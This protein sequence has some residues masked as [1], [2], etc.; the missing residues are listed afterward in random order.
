M[1]IELFT[2]CQF[3]IIIPTVGMVSSNCDPG[4]VYYPFYIFLQFSPKYQIIDI[5]RLTNL[6][7]SDETLENNDP[8]TPGEF[9][10]VLVS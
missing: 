9:L 4:G 6:D 8:A 1:T 7:L 2:P 5:V 10:N 3:A